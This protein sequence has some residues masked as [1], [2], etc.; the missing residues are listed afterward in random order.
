MNEIVPKPDAIHITARILPGVPNL[1]REDTGGWLWG[2]FRE[3]FP[4]AL[5]FC[6]LPNHPHIVVAGIDPDAAQHRVARLLGHFRRTFS[7]DGPVGVVA[8]PKPIHGVPELRRQVRY[9]ALNPCR[10][11]LVRCPLAWTWTTHRDAIGA[12]VDPW[13]DARRLARVFEWPDDGVAE[14]LH[15]YVSGDPD[16]HVAGTRMPTPAASATTPAIGL[17]AVADAVIAATRTSFAALRRRGRTRELF[18][19]LAYDQG[20]DLPTRL[21]EIC[22]C[23]PLAIRRLAQHVDAAALRAARLCLGDARLRGGLPQPAP[24]SA[25]A[26]PQHR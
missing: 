19:S 25:A 26:R 6:L 15:A 24:A 10:A 22:G 14:R 8:P 23:R 21:A 12:I 4:D 18:V 13:V 16:A 11:K 5:G 9:V 20:W 7:L 3:A 1:C 2:G 17:R